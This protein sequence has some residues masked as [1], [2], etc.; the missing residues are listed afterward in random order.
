MCFSASASFTASGILTLLGATA[1]FKAR[2]TGMR[3]FAATPFIFALQQ[4]A[5]GVVWLTINDPSSFLHKLAVFMFLFFALVL[6]PLW[7]PCCLRYLET[8]NIR[9]IM[10]NVIVFLGCVFALASLYTLIR[11]EAT[12]I[13]LN[14]HIKYITTFHHPRAAAM[15]YIA[16]VTV[17]CFIS[18]VRYM[19]IFGLGIFI[20]LLVTI[21]LY[22][23]TVGSVWCFFTEILSG[24]II[25][26]VLKN[27]KFRVE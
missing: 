4:A 11:Y 19:W 2:S 13:A 25:Y 7:I 20:S 16:I 17:P 18:S 14:H 3:F 22:P 24:F 21:Y 10:I 1:I 6:W 8:G 27:K 5:E 26:L 12:A 9:K 15:I 23:L